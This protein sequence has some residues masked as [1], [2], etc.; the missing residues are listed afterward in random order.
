MLGPMPISTEELIEVPEK[1]I[2]YRRQSGPSERPAPCQLAR[3][4]RKAAATCR[5]ESRR[6]ERRRRPEAALL[7]TW[8]IDPESVT[9]AISHG[10]SSERASDG[11]VKLEVSPVLVSLI[12]G[13]EPIVLHAPDD[14]RRGDAELIS[15]ARHT[16]NIE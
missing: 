15:K 8:R 12:P 7:S 3:Q 1:E 2:A 5:R 16:G 13:E 10:I 9:Q 14:D 11:L 4:L 6:H